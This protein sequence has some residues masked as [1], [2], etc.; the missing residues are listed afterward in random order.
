[1][2]NF[3]PVLACGGPI[4]GSQAVWLI[5]SVWLI[6]AVLALINLF[7]SLTL[8]TDWSKRLV[9]LSGWAFYTI[10]A[11]LLIAAGSFSF[12]L[13]MIIIPIAPALA[14]FHFISLICLRYKL[15]C[16]VANEQQRDT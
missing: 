3:F 6:G 13:I 11:P 2:N 10:G 8:K 5:G 12:S 1:M 14:L 9:N 7:W 4:I 16:G 15:R